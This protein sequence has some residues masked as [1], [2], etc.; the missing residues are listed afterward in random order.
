MNLKRIKL[1]S[2]DVGAM[3]DLMSVLL[4]LNRL[5]TLVLPT[6]VPKSFLALAHRACRQT[7]TSLTLT[8]HAAR[9][10][11]QDLLYIEQFENLVEL[12]ILPQTAEYTW[13]DTGWTLRCLR[14][15]NWRGGHSAGN[16]LADSRFL[17]GC[18]FPA[19]R[20][21]SVYL[22]TLANANETMHLATFLRQHSF[23]ERLQL[24]CCTEAMAADLLSLT[25]CYSFSALDFCPV[26]LTSFLPPS[27][28][29]LT[30]GFAINGA[31]T[32]HFLDVFL[33][34]TQTLD[35]IRIELQHGGSFIWTGADSSPHMAMFVAKLL[36]YAKRLR[37]RGTLL[38]DERGDALDIFPA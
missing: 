24:A 11:A 3:D 7:L 19:L 22:P 32:Q 21:A 33:S 34:G 6:H 29:H 38:V 14:K 25:S 26:T 37:A 20:L 16:D 27:I 35:T 23:I 10:V 8:D 28:R 12:S 36:P 17:A 31:N 1:H 2:T 4:F 9:L 18:Q 30:V 15:L 13:P 5:E